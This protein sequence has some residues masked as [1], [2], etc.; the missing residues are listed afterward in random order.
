MRQSHNIINLELETI[1]INYVT[2]PQLFTQFLVFPFINNGI[3]T[4]IYI[5]CCKIRY[6]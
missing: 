1:I 6:L 4:L 5:D 3:L 2:Q